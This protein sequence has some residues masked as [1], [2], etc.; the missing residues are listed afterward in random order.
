VICS[1]P[2]TGHFLSQDRPLRVETGRY[3]IT[4]NLFVGLCENSLSAV[5]RKRRTLPLERLES[6][7]LPLPSTDR[8]GFFW[9]KK[10]APA[11]LAGAS[12]FC[13]ELRHYAEPRQHKFRF[14]ELEYMR[15][16]FGLRACARSLRFRWP[17]KR[18]IEG[19][20]A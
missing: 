13:P 7:I 8:R 5:V 12:L 17:V 10:E 18:V 20:K 1:K 3:P 16:K 6:S 11:R 4:E 14:T 15:G 19:T 2:K 9:K